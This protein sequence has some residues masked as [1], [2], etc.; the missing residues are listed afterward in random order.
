MSHDTPI[1]KTIL[2][3]ILEK[4]LEEKLQSF[5][6][7]MSMMDSLND[8]VKFP[9]DQ[10]DSICKKVDALEAKYESSGIRE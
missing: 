5:D 6:R 1:T 9:S 3:A 7:L 10:F 8:S 4:K 2:E